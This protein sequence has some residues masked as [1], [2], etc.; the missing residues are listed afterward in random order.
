MLIDAKN[1]LFGVFFFLLQ[2]TAQQWF[3]Q[4]RGR[5]GWGVQT[6]IKFRPSLPFSP[7]GGFMGE[8]QRGGNM[9]SMKTQ[10]DDGAEVPQMDQTFEIKVQVNMG[11]PF[12]LLKKTF[13]RAHVYVD[14]W[15]HLFQT[16]WSANLN[17]IFWLGNTYAQ[18]NCEKKKFEMSNIF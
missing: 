13:Y 16:G 7:T 11:S 1:P 4:I 5:R 10:R 17:D 14:E 15:P 18:I 2:P 6:Q 3:K 8:G 12:S 9:I